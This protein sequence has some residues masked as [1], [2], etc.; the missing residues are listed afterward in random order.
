MVLGVETQEISC[1]NDTGGTRKQ[2]GGAMIASEI[3]LVG[4]IALF[5]FVVIYCS[6]AI[7]LMRRKLSMGKRGID[8]VFDYH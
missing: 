1:K 3:A 5:I 6:V 2:G 8:R 7:I 4:F